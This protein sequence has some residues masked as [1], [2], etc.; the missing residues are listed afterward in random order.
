M[1]E[2]NKS[3]NRA[4]RRRRKALGR[5]GFEMAEAARALGKRPEALRRLVEHHA[6]EEGDEIVARLVGGI[7]ARKKRG[8]GRWTI[9]IPAA[10]RDEA[11]E[12]TETKHEVKS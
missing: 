12:T 10:L 9:F 7:V 11:T 4:A 8:Y 5:I 2:E 1:T 3:M 6:Q